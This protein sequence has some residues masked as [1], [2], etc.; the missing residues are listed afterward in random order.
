MVHLS[1]YDVW[2][3]P[4]NLSSEGYV[5]VG[6]FFTLSGFILVI[7][8][9]AG[10]SARAFYRR[11]FARIYRAYLTMV[12]VVLVVPVVAASRGPLE[13]RLGHPDAIVV[14]CE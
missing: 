1:Q 13:V 11:R 7:A 6:F 10:D 14:S 12:I 9:P 3:L 5:G 2:R 4:L 8:A